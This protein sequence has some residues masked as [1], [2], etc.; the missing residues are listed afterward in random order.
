VRQFEMHPLGS[1]RNQELRQKTL[2]YWRM[3]HC[4]RNWFSQWNRK[5]IRANARKFL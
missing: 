2:F 5:G 4:P 1:I 3:M